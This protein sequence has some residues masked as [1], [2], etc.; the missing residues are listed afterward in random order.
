M[1]S[2]N[3]SAAPAAEVSEP[4]APVMYKIRLKS[5]VSLYGM[6]FKPGQD[7]TVDEATKRALGDAVDHAEQV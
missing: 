2:K 5:V 6:L 7:I 1:S 4:S 3:S